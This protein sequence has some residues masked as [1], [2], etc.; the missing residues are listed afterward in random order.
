[1]KSTLTF[2]TVGYFGPDLFCD[3]DSEIKRL[4]NNVDSNQSTMLTSIRRMGKTGLI[5]HF[6]YQLSD[7]YKGI[8]LDILP[9]ENL[10]EFLNELATSIIRSIPEKSST[11][12][13][14]WNF[15]KS[16]RP[17]ISFDQFNGDLKISFDLTKTEEIKTEINSLFR[18]LENQK[19]K[20]VIAIDEFQQ[21]INYPEKN[22]D[23][24]FRTIIQ[25]L[26][27]IVFIFSGSQQHIMNDLFTSPTKPFYR[28]TAILELN[29]IKKEVYAD[30]IES[31]F[32][33]KK[34]QI[35]AFVVDEIL[36][37]TLVHTFYVQQVCSRLYSTGI[38][39]ITSETWKQEA[40][41][42]LK[43]QESTFYNFRE[44][45]TTPQWKLLKGIATETQLYSPTNKIF[46]SKNKLGASASVLR[47]LN[48]LIDK[49]MVCLLFDKEGKKYYR[50]YDVF[51]MRW[52]QN[53]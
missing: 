12:K 18:L 29:P 22:C 4:Q 45:L 25:K 10:S 6:F 33:A 15:I 27:N 9:T 7:E 44:L 20:S 34:R 35:P 50:L 37:W 17:N 43:E 40:F 36:D 53:L 39:N 32:N 24:W 46:I 1:M 41:K 28:S 26:Q 23:A 5:K 30:F 51:L 11:G 52:I 49:E 16:I 48:A 8:Y 47:S 3:R 13:K 31:K 21:I 14:I 19:F 42:L 2:P 38:K